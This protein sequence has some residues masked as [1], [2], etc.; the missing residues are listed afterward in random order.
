MVCDSIQEAVVEFMSNT[1]QSTMKKT[2]QKLLGDNNVVA[3]GGVLSFSGR[4]PN[5]KTQRA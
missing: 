3:R 1:D 5:G 4:C 2:L